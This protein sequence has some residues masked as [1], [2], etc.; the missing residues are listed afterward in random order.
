MMARPMTQSASYTALDSY[1]VQEDLEPLE[2]F[3]R[4]MIEETWKIQLWQVEK[5]SQ[6]HKPLAAF[7][8]EAPR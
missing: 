1:D 2:E 8:G 7:A 4:Q 3:F 5:E 6:G